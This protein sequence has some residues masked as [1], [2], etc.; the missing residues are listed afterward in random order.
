MLSDNQIYDAE[1]QFDTIK[2]RREAREKRR[3]NMD[4]TLNSFLAVLAYHTDVCVVDTATDTEILRTRD[5]GTP[6]AIV[7]DVPSSDYIVLAVGQYS[8]GIIVFVK[9]RA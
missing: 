3:H 8:E 7:G 6:Y 2:H 1:Q 9:R 5:F 4:F